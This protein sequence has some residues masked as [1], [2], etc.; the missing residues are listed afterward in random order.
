MS[1]DN[2]TRQFIGKSNNSFGYYKGELYLNKKKVRKNVSKV[3][4]NALSDKLKI[5]DRIGVG[6]DCKRRTFFVVKN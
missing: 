4:T 2:N 1:K 5:R 6:I 3:N